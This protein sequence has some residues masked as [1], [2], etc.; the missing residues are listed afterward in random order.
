VPVDAA[1]DP[2]KEKLAASR[3]LI[4]SVGKGVRAA[5]K[6]AHD[7]APVTKIETLAAGLAEVPDVDHRG[8]ATNTIMG[9][10]DYFFNPGADTFGRMPSPDVR[11]LENILGG[12]RDFPGAGVPDLA[13]RFVTEQVDALAMAKYVL[14]VRVKEHTPTK[15]NGPKFIYGSV[16]G[17][18]FLYD[19]TGKRLGAFPF[20]ITGKQWDGMT[21]KTGDEQDTWDQDLNSSVFEQLDADFA[22]FVAAK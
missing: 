13:L 16:A 14:V 5:A 20:K 6:D 15:K 12:S 22:K 21:V 7:A 11:E 10:L 19:L 9:T 17:D 3:A 1:P 8:N 18:A 4:E 2:I